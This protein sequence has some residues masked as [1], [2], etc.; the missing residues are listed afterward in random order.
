MKFYKCFPIYPGKIGFILSN[1]YET[2][3]FSNYS[4]HVIDI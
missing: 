2:K 3:P 4:V 1:Y